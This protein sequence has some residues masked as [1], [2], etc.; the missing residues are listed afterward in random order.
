MVSYIIVILVLCGIE[1]TSRIYGSDDPPGKR[2]IGVVL[3]FI[4]FCTAVIFCSI[5]GGW[6]VYSRWKRRFRI[7]L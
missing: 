2:V 7:I 4:V 5:L 3:V 1:F 6:Y